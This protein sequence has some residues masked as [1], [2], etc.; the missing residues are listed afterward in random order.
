MELPD[1][2]EVL[3][4]DAA[5]RDPDS[6]PKPSP[7]AGLALPGAPRPARDA[8]RDPDAP[9]WQLLVLTF[10]PDT[11]LDRPLP[12][13]DISPH[14]R[15][16][17]L[18][19]ETGVPA[20]IVWGGGRLRLVSAPRGESSGHL[21]FALADLAETAGRPI[22][23]ALRLLLGAPRVLGLPKGKRLPALLAESRQ[24][25]N[26]V[27]EKLAGQVLEGLYDLLRGV[28]AADTAW[29]GRLLSE[30]LRETPDQVYR[31]LLA[32]ILRLVFLLYAEQRGLLPDDPT[33]VRHYSLTALF[34][35][36]RAD[37]ALHPDTM[38]QR[39][40][41]LGAPADPLPH[42]LRRRPLREDAAPR[43]ARGALRS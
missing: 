13:S 1:T 31:G 23:G 37:A 17:R 28:Q 20:G 33:F 25:Q 18:L 36:L 41:G 19:R 38:D 30:T 15:M 29:G 14:G 3:R 39:R 16:E 21:D 34:E 2:G 10:G 35:R 43:P 40:G 6:L 9:R 4:P 32:V 24:Y 26:E 5:V 27:S 22:L 7:L 11:T 12:G 8:P 42:G